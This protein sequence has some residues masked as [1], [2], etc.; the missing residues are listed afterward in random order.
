MSSNDITRSTASTSLI[1]NIFFKWNGATFRLCII[2]E[3]MCGMKPFTED[4]RPLTLRELISHILMNL[5]VVSNVC[6]VSIRHTLPQCIPKTSSV[7]THPSPSS[8]FLSTI[9]SHCNLPHMSAV[10]FTCS[11]EHRWTATARHLMPLRHSQ[12][13]QTNR[14]SGR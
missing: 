5:W 1:L 13:C 2:P 4:P 6:E 3:M 7:H 8:L 12:T 11:R 9:F 10:W 14:C